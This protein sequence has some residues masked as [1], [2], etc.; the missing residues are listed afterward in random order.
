M[1][2][3]D[4]LDRLVRA[5]SVNPGMDPTGAG[6]AEVARILIDALG[7][8]GL[9]AHE[10]EVLPGRSNVVGVLPGPEGAPTLMLEA[11]M[12]TVP[13]GDEPIEVRREDGR[14]LGRGT[15]DTKG[16]LAAMVAAVATLAAEDGP[17]PTVVLAATVDEEAG[18]TGAEHLLEHAPRPDAAVVGEP[19]SLLPVRVHNGVLRVAIVARGR[20]AHTSKAHLG[21][22]AVSAAAR[23]IA[24]IEADV[25][26][27]LAD[28]AHP[29][30]GPALLTASMVRGGVA[31]NIVPERCEVQLDRRLAPGETADDALAELEAV[32]ERLRADGDDVRLDTPQIALP[33]VET[34]EGDAVVRAAEAAI[35]TAAGGAP[36]TTDASRIS[37]T[38][39]VPCLVLGPGSIDQAHTPDEWVPLEEVERAVELYVGLARRFAEGA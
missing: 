2:V 18:M 10:H 32:L 28:R 27:G 20:Q 7:A 31:S 4:L 6:E 13:E 30:A 17:R 33:P 34:P 12:D 29:L 25:G 19:T 5:S 26:A 9:E 16:A 35:G 23:V 24:A 37:G 22:N 11:H 15:C 21:V 1:D 3:L 36:Y 38:G 39:G 8:L 14:L